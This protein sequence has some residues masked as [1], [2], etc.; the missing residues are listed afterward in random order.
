[1]RDDKITAEIPPH[2]KCRAQLL[3]FKNIVCLLNITFSNILYAMYAKTLPFFPKKETIGG[4]F[5]V[6]LTNLILRVLENL[7]YP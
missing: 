3:I 7:T 5:A 6:N 1:M 4:G 2:L